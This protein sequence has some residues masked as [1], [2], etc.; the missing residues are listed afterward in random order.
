MKDYSAVL[1]EKIRNGEQ[2]ALYCYGILAGHMLYRL[3]TFHGV[4]PAVVVDNDEQK[5]G[6][7]EFGVPVMPF[8]DARE[9]FQ[10]LQ[11][12]ICTDD[13]K[14]AII[15]DMLEKGVLPENIVN[16]VPVKKEVSCLPLR[17]RLL[18]DLYPAEAG[19]HGV[20]SCCEAAF[21][22]TEK[23]NQ[24]AIQFPF[25][26][27][28]YPDL[29]ARLDA[30]MSP[31]EEGRT[32]VC[33]G[34]PLWQEQYMVAREYER[35]WKQVAF[36]QTSCVDCLSHCVY[37]CAGAADKDV[38]ASPEFQTDRLSY[39]AGFVNRLLAFGRLDDD[40][41]CT[42]DMSERDIDCKIGFVADALQ[43]AGLSPLIYKIGSCLMTYSGNLE[44]LLRQGKAYIIW[45]LDAGTRETYRKIKQVDVFDH[46]LENVKRY[47][48][49][50]VFS[51]RFIVAKYLIVKGINDNEKE[52]DE[53]LRLVLELGLTYVS[54]S[55]DFYVKAEESDLE[56][57]RS[58]YQKICAHGLQLTNKN[59]SE[60]V[61]A[62]LSMTSTRRQTV[63]A[64]PKINERRRYDVKTEPNFSVH[65]RV[66]G[67]GGQK[68][69]LKPN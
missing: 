25:E 26:E 31:F 36:Y 67:R 23:V 46:V 35:R 41:T 39:Y 5:R 21:E 12:F 53:Y 64:V 28:G 1:A 30:L 68:P 55:F 49:H 66:D 51:G 18:I 65:S 29:E 19:V 17:S 59:N 15:G 4:L 24:T 37:C 45:S 11:Y 2:V 34:C 27:E 63:T 7:A 14:Y 60:V 9:R 3:K 8:A 50:D 48:S 33:R 69:P 6:N 20:R 44:E 58:C 61:T 54:L 13:F 57:I 38:K 43:R 62:A 32:E 16:Y 40:F 22:N 52:F 47:I 10:N 56:F 42:I